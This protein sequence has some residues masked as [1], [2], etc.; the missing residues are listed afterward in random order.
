MI[1]TS[2]ID[3]FVILNY[4]A[5]TNVFAANQT[6]HDKGVF[7]ITNIVFQYCGTSLKRGATQC[8][9]YGRELSFLCGRK[10]ILKTDS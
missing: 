2:S 8:N 4:P 3:F 10:T 5:P 7:A 1:C 6:I 9:G